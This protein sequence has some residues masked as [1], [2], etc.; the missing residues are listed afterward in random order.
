MQRL[1]LF[2]LCVVFTRA[3][4]LC[5]QTN[6]ELAIASEE[7]TNEAAW[8]HAPSKLFQPGQFNRL[9]Q[10]TTGTICD[11][12]RARH[13]ARGISAGQV[14]QRLGQTANEN[15]SPDQ[16]TVALKPKIHVSIRTGYLYY[17]PTTT[18][19]NFQSTYS[20][21]FEI[22]FGRKI[23]IGLSIDYMKFRGTTHAQTGG[24]GLDPSH[25]FISEVI[26]QFYAFAL[27]FK[28][29]ARPERHMM[30]PYGGMKIGVVKRTFDIGLES[31]ARVND[32]QRIGLALLIGL[33]FPITSFFA[34]NSTTDYFLT[35]A[36]TE[37]A[38]DPTF[39]AARSYIASTLGICFKF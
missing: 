6:A 35:S 12:T 1:T 33:E 19:D 30:T 8:R 29:Q 10:E 24:G 25:K 3:A 20:A 17:L 16:R 39:N 38:W 21:G 23:Y 31:Y 27:Y 14:N 37:N 4:I 34:I 26:G 5:A 18:S 2:I 36:A 11:E 22:V 32:D 13:L 9:A 28:P 15:D 7:F